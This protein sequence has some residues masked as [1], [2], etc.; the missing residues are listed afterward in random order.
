MASQ[1]ISIDAVTADVI[2]VTIGGVPCT[3]TATNT[4]EDTQGALL[5]TAINALSG[6][7]G[8]FASYASGGGGGAAGTLTITSQYPGA[9]SN[10][11]TLA[12]SGAGKGDS[13]VT[14]GLL[15]G[16]FDRVEIECIV[17]GVIGNAIALVASGTGITVSAALLSE[18]SESRV[19]YTL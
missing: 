6:T 2:T 3:I 15:D 1:T 5:V 19:A 16:G 17:P 12:I 9:A 8:C 11:V 7:H 13:A 14:A 10:E 18:G 4:D